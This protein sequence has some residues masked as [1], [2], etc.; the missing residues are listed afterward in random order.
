VQTWSGREALHQHERLGHGDGVHG[1][2]E[3]G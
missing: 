3:D 2:V 1:G